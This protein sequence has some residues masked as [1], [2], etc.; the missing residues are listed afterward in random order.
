MKRKIYLPETLASIFQFIQKKKKKRQKQQETL[1]NGLFTED[2]R[3]I[4]PTNAAQS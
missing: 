2:I 1:P 4:K 3:K